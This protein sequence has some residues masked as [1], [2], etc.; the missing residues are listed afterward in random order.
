M[1]PMSKPIIRTLACVLLFCS[2]AGGGAAAQDGRFFT[3]PPFVFPAPPKRDFGTDELAGFC[4]AKTTDNRAYLLV[5]L[6]NTDRTIDATEQALD[7]LARDLGLETEKFGCPPKGFGY[8]V[9]S[10]LLKS[11][12]EL[13]EFVVSDEL[14][15]PP[16]H[17]SPPLC[18]E[19]PPRVSP[20]V[21]RP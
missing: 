16:R 17:R 21:E 3:D 10:Y 4:F 11:G 5:A 2:C 8:L 19:P 12:K 9:L 6:R 1:D 20:I 15:G 14:L 7:R 18:V 13:R